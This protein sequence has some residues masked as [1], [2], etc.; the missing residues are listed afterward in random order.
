[1]K[2]GYDPFYI[3]VNSG[4]DPLNAPSYLVPG[5]LE[6]FTN[7]VFEKVFDFI[8]DSSMLVGVSHLFSDRYII[9]YKEKYRDKK[10]ILCKC[11]IRLS[12]IL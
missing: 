4:N 12:S 9:I 3:I 11:Q 5:F 2:G 1:M 6:P 7:C 10:Y 8:A